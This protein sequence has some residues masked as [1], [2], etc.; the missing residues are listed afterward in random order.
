V[1]TRVRWIVAVVVVL[2]GLIH[3]LGGVKGFGWAEVTALTEPISTLLGV[4]WLIAALLVVLAG[5]MLATAAGSWW[6]V[7]AVAAVASQGVILTS[8]TD[9]KA[10]T[11]VN[12]VLLVAAGY[13]YAS[14]GPKS[15]R[16]EYRHRVETALAQTHSG[17]VVNE[18]D[19]ASLPEAVA[20]YVR[21]SGAVGQPRVA[22]FRARIHGRIRGG[23]SKP[24][25][26]FTGEQ[27]N[28]YGSAPCRLFFMDATM[29][30]LPLDVLHVF[31]GRR[32][33]MR[34]KAC[35]LVTMVDAAG[36]NM[37]RAETVTLFNDLAVLAPA[38]LID[39]PITWQAVDD[40]H[41]RGAFTN[42]AYTVTAQLI[43]NDA[44]E[45]VDFISDD[46]LAASA[47]GKRFTPKRW[48][49]PLS[50]YRTLGARRI[51]TNGQGRWHAPAPEGDFSYLEFNLD[52]I[53]YN[54][55]S[56]DAGRMRGADSLSATP[57]QLLT[58]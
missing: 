18:A 42:G 50:G 54:T 3:L 53:N 24:W 17:G 36:P 47:D 44:H 26:T 33:T 27:V 5:V 39:A 13:G 10:G 16:A 23:A 29:R 35:S 31:V 7:G 37:D 20:A 19:L 8:W 12:V 45:L 28:T 48:S 57:G 41:V 58:S 51:A 6:I 11:L 25:M 46:R 43:F 32:A 4:T 14:Q 30:G 52:Q 15:Y 49:T 2:H 22:N 21:Q 34:V 1:R 38:A 40:Q 55:R 9:A 56:A